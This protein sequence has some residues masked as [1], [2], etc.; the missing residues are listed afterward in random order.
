MDDRVTEIFEKLKYEV[1]A[2]HVKWIFYRQLYASKP[3]DI[4]LLNRHGS[5]VFYMFQMQTLDEVCLIFS[6]LTDPNRQGSNE[7]LSLK[8]LIVF[9]N[10]NAE[11]EFAQELKRKFESVKEACETFRVLRNKRI[12]HAD[13]T[14]GLGAASEPLPGIS[15]EYVE[16]ALRLLRELMNHFE[17]HYR[18]SKTAY[19]MVI[20][21]FTSDGNKLLKALR[22]AEKYE[23][24][25]AENA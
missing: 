23:A 16:S 3:E 15:R 17:L 22:N 19:D 10:D 9:A 5:N 11:P 21:P 2:L 4:E 18:D 14:H 12:A 13:L 6:K 7:N 1:N 20:I 24:L 8:Q 25:E